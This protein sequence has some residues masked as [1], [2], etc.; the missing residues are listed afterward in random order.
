MKWS[1]SLKVLF[2]IATTAVLS[3]AMLWA[4]KAIPGP[5]YDLG[6]EVTV[7][8][9]VEEIKIQA[10]AGEGLHFMLK[11]A[12]E[13]VLVHVAPESFLKEM[14]FEIPKGAQVEVRGSKIKTDGGD[15]IL[16]REIDEKGNT[17]TLRDRKGAPIWANW[18]PGKK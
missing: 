15:E 10:G 6:S 11:E 3:A 16:A 18:D 12:N 1:L 7:K 5:K 9:T 2:A 4:Q 8:G 17:L 14:D 13:T